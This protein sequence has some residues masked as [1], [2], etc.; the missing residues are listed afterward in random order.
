MKESHVESYDNYTHAVAKPLSRIYNASLN[1]GICSDRLK[2]VTVR[3]IYN[4]KERQREREREKL[5]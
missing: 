1:Q 5:M 2:F 3:P 4:K